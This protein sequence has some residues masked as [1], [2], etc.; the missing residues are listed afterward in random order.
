MEPVLRAWL[1]AEPDLALPEL[2]TRLAKQDVSIEPGALR[3]QFN[4]G[5]TVE[6]GGR[7]TISK[8]APISCRFPFGIRAPKLK[9]RKIDSATVIARTYS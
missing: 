6:G 7:R 1:E 3:P 2:S 8:M 4:D 5:Q 9:G